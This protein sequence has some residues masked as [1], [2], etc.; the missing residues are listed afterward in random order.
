[1]PF[2][3][4]SHSNFE[5]RLVKHL[6]WRAR[7][8][9]PEEDR[10]KYGFYYMVNADGTP[11]DED[12]LTKFPD[13]GQQETVFGA[14]NRGRSFALFKVPHDTASANLRDTC[15]LCSVFPTNLSEMVKVSWS[16]IV[17]GCCP[18]IENMCLKHLHVPLL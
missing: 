17:C 13:G 4:W 6:D 2:V 8:S 14:S 12:D 15:H 3:N 9:E 11:F 5:E 10:S 18:S 16:A 7:K 1:M